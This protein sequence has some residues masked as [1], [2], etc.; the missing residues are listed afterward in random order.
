LDQHD[1]VFRCKTYRCRFNTRDLWLWASHFT[2][3]VY[4]PF[5]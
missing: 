3:I 4:S 1:L 5:F 2:L